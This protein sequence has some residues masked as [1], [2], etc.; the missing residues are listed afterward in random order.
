MRNKV[1]NPFFSKIILYLG[2]NKFEGNTENTRSSIDDR[3][4]ERARFCPY[5]KF[6]RRNGSFTIERGDRPYPRLC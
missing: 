4:S 2:V 1:T 5:Y 6:F 3:G